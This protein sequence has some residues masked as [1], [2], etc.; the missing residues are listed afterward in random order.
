MRRLV[1]LFTLCLNAFLNAVPSELS[2]L[3]GN[4]DLIGR[5]NNLS[6][7]GIAMGN[8]YILTGHASVGFYSSDIDGGPSSSMFD[9]SNMYNNKGSSSS[10]NDLIDK[11]SGFWAYADLDSKII[12]D[13]VTLNIHTNLSDTIFVE[14]L[15]LNFD[16]ADS[17]SVDAGKFVSHR[18][19]RAEEA[20]ER[21]MRG[22][23]YF[24]SE[25]NLGNTISSGLQNGYYDLVVDLFTE[26]TTDMSN[27]AKTVTGLLDTSD[28]D[29]QK[30]KEELLEN[31]T[32]IYEAFGIGDKEITDISDALDAGDMDALQQASFDLTMALSDAVAQMI[33]DMALINDNYRSSSNKGIRG[34]LKFDFLQFSA[35]IT[36]SIWNNK[37]DMGD[38]SIAIDLQ[39]VAYIHPA[40]AIKTGYAFEKVD[41]LGGIVGLLIPNSDDN[42]HQFHIGGELALG[43]FTAM[44]EFGD[45]SINPYDTDIWDIALL[46]HYQFTDLFGL[47]LLYSHE[48]LDTPFGDGD[49]DLFNIA[50]NFNFTRNLMFGIDYTTS[51]A[52]LGG[53]KTDYDLFTVNTLYSF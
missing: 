40:F 42:I 22:Q 31:L 25:G 27:R 53:A 38:G 44:L 32:P 52:K 6:R 37:P 49:S 39:A 50:L 26:F 9:F 23:T 33:G 8:H 4:E 21:F 16:I 5:N 24:N 51:D 2:S 45:T 15:Y 47:G 17:F 12:F 35:A 3:V 10:M 43:D 41:K 13:P 48:E 28:P 14:Q 18:T 36:E 1:L 29:Y 20:N 11:E 19:L 34:N 7:N 30:D 46:L